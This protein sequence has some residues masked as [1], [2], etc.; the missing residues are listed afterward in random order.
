MIQNHLFQLLC[1]IAMEPPVTYKANE[2]QNRKIDVLNAV[3]P[4]SSPEKV[5]TNTVRGQYGSGWIK[6]KEIKG[7][8][9]AKGVDPHSNT[10]TFAAL[11]I[12]LDNW[13][14]KD[15]P[16]YLRTG[17][18][19]KEKN[20][21]ITIQFK[22]V[23][24]QLFPCEVTNA[25]P[26]LLVISIQPKTGIRLGMQA[27]RPGLKMLLNNVEMSFDYDDSFSSPSPE[28]YET[29]L[30]D[31]MQG[32]STLFMRADQVEAAWKIIM[33]VLENWENNETAD[34]PNYEA[35]SWGPQQSEALLARDG[36]SWL[37]Y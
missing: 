6:G 23:S 32:D 16:F 7:Y 11:K 28:A 36:R 8:R 29:L 25:S 15:V 12:Y 2:I 17:K 30:L 26:N 37:V 24:H 9:S 35:G 33:P 18:S 5:R 27:K 22:P 3:R 31:V 19:L 10:D 14:W 21:S 4:Y 1:L 13:R 20:S 34:F